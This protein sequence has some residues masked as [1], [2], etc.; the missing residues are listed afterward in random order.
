MAAA[1]FHH[2]RS[3]GFRKGTALEKVFRESE[4]FATGDYASF[5]TRGASIP[6]KERTR[7]LSRLADIVGLSLDIVT[8]AEGR[9]SILTFVREL[10]RDERKVL[11]LYDTTITATDPFPIATSS[12]GR[13]RRCRGSAPRTPWRSIECFARRSAS[14]QIAS[15]CSCRTR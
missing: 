5:L 13:I 1:A 3:R 2:G 12:P 6:A 15:T 11:G 7:I 8:R 14:R 4:E 10:L 9:V